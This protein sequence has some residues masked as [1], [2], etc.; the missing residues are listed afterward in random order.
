MARISK[1]EL[2]VLQNTLKT[3]AKIGE[4]FGI[5]R[6][7]VHQLRQKYGLDYNKI[8]FKDRDDEVV[9]LYREGKSGVKVAQQLNISISQVYRILKK[10]E[11]TPRRKKPEDVA[12]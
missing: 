2:I 11:A 5:S 3:D 12:A 1:D 7:A 8:K 9:T 10:Y 6:Q 4:K